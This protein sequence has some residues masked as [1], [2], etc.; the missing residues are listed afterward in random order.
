MQILRYV[1]PTLRT[2]R[3]NDF[4]PALQPSEPELNLNLFKE[5]LREIADK[6]GVGLVPY[7]VW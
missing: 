7:E 6:N 1:L 3:K 4:V 2:S 5:R